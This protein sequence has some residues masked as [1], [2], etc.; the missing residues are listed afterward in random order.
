MGNASLI[1]YHRFLLESQSTYRF[2]TNA[3]RPATVDS[4]LI[5]GTIVRPRNE[6][7]GLVLRSGYQPLRLAT[8]LF[9]TL[10]ALLAP[11]EFSPFWAVLFYFS[12][13]AFGIAQQVIN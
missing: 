9:P 8:E 1:C 3:T 7:D 5:L 13:V 2:L 4:N 6:S 12:L 10:V 11:A